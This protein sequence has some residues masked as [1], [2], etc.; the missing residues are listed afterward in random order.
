MPIVM[1]GMRNVKPT[2]PVTMTA[3][4]PLPPVR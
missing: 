4:L 2:D 1:L 3:P